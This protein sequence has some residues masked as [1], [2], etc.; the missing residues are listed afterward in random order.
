MSRGSWFGLG[1]GQGTP[2]DIPYVETDFI[3]AAVTEELGI[4]F[5]I[6]LIFICI[7]CFL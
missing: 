6:C 3:F 4:I 7:S 5:S 1:I 2:K